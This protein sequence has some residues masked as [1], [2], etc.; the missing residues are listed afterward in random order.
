VDKN[1]INPIVQILERIYQILRDPHPRKDF[2]AQRYTLASA[3]T[4]VLNFEI[5]PH[6]YYIVVDP[7]STAGALLEIIDGEFAAAGWI[8]LSPGNAVKF[9]AKVARL[10]L[11]NPGTQSALFTVIALGDDDFTFV[12]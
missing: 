8:I 6:Y 5:I 7:A 2:N 3:A 11:R 1:E 10:F 4:Q 12:H 9:P